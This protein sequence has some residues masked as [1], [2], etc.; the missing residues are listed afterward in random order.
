VIA[1]WGMWMAS[2]KYLEWIGRVSHPLRASLLILAGGAVGTSLT[3]SRTLLIRHHVT[4][5]PSRVNSLHG[6]ITLFLSQTHKQIKKLLQSCI[7]ANVQTYYTCNS[8]KTCISDLYHNC[9][10]ISWV[11]PIAML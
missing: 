1:F 11:F 7:H 10:L 8:S 9:F 5:H 3:M 4:A 6:T 2:R